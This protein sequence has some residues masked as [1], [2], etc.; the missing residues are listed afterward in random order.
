[1]NEYRELLGMAKAQKA[2]NWAVKQEETYRV[3]PGVVHT[4]RQLVD[5]DM[6]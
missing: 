6:L 2:R 5:R 1:M 3:A 4:I